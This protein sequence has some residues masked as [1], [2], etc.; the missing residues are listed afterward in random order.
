MDRLTD[1]PLGRSFRRP[2]EQRIWDAVQS[3]EGLVR[4]GQREVEESRLLA[5]RT[6]SGLTQDL[7]DDVATS[8]EVTRLVGQVVGGQ[9]ATLA[10]VVVDG[11]RQVSASADDVAEGLV[12]RLFR[13]KPRQ[14][15]PPSPVAG[16]PQTMYSEPAAGGEFGDE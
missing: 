8:P 6:A 10:G 2:F 1:N 15:L 9:S 11:A 4:E 5:K 14:D 16:V 13:R 3:A 7:I 12:R